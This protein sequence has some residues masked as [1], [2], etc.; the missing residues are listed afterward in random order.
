MIN[1]QSYWMIK[2]QWY[3]GSNRWCTCHGRRNW[4]GVGLSVQNGDEEG[5][6]EGR[7]PK[8]NSNCEVF[9]CLQNLKSA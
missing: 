3:K 8:K 6:G 4:L 1:L 2:S 5:G 9:F 7:D